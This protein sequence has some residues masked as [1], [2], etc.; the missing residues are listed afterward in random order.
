MNIIKI[1]IRNASRFITTWLNGPPLR[2]RQLTLFYTWFWYILIFRNS[3]YFIFQVRRRVELN[4]PTS[5]WP[6]IITSGCMPQGIPIHCRQRGKEAT[7]IMNTE[8]FYVGI[9]ILQPNLWLREE[10]VVNPAVVYPDT[11]RT[12]DTAAA[13]PSNFK[14]KWWKF[15]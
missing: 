8:Q 2:C 7:W 4:T 1:Q 5:R 15:P 14:C 13:D 11:S 9:L 12:T 6:G 3:I 10:D